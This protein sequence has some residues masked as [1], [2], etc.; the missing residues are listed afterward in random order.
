[1]KI[2][3]G[4]SNEAVWLVQMKKKIGSKLTATLPDCKVF[5]L[6]PIHVL[7][8]GFREMKQILILRIPCWMISLWYTL[9]LRIF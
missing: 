9:C 2:D 1:M 6:L 5:C 8:Q 3:R 4:M 7:P